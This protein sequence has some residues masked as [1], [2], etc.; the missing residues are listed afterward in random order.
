MLQVNPYKDP[1]TTS[2]I[3]AGGYISDADQNQIEIMR[4]VCTLKVV[5]FK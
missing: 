1:P 4:Q 5:A 2:T 3:S